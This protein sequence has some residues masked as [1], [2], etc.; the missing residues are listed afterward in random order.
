MRFSLKYLFMLGLVFLMFGCSEQTPMS[1]LSDNA[2]E[3][4]LEKLAENFDLRGSVKVMTWNVYV[5]ANVDIVL[6]ATDPLDLAQRV[7]AAYDTVQQ[8]NF[9]ERAIKIAS[10]IKKHRPQLIGLQ[11]ISLIQ[12]L[13]QTGS[14]VLEELDYLNIL[15][16]ALAA[17]KLNYGL[18]DIIHNADVTMPLLAGW[19]GTDPII[20]YVRLRDSDVILVQRDVQFSNSIKGNYSA[21]LPIP[22]LGITIPRGYVS[23][24]AQVSNRSYRFINTHLEAFT[25]QVRL[26]QAMELALVFS[27]ETLPVILVGDFNTT[28]PTLVNPFQD[29]TYQFLT[30]TAGYEDSWIHNLWGNQGDGNT[31][32]FQSDLRDPFANL[33]Q[34]IDLIFVGNYGSPAGIH[35]IG[36]V[37]AEVI[38]DE[39]RDRTPSGLWPSDHAGVFA[40]LHISEVNRIIAHHEQSTIILEQ[41]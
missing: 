4:Q 35:P 5:G 9:P 2:S 8:T 13:D 41:D 18:A 40:Q 24:E 15:L 11:E 22:S 28:D 23:V 37:R 29:A 33:Y 17:Q 38:G 19:N 31:S 36:P 26:P 30:Q 20:E 16:N 32:P 34:R 21:A 27:S 7:A 6:N 10:I 1:P 3:Y 25:E 12:R 14:V 39:Q